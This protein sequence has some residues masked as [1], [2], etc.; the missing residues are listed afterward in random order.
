M[1]MT[2]DLTVAELAVMMNEAFQN[3][4]VYMEERFRRVEERLD[5]LE[6]RVTVIENTMSTKT[7]IQTLTDILRTNGVLSAFETSQVKA[8]VS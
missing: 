7:Q 1:T 4:Q 8:A 2:K 3:L 6:V 5:A